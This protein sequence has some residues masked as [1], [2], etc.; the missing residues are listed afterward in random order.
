MYKWLFSGQFGGCVCSKRRLFFYC[1]SHSHPST[2]ISPLAPTF[3]WCVQGVWESWFLSGWRCSSELVWNL[4]KKAFFPLCLRPQQ[5]W[6]S[7]SDL[8]EPVYCLIDQWSE[9][10]AS[11]LSIGNQKH[12]FC[13]ID[14]WSETHCSPVNDWLSF[15]ETSVTSAADQVIS[16]FSYIK[17]CIS[18]LEKHGVI[19]TV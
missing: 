10:S 17:C 18:H 1:K 8:P 4:T 6:S 3:S 7:L 9:S 14:Q 2:V 12:V 16:C 15:T 19:Y 11:S 13:S 5:N